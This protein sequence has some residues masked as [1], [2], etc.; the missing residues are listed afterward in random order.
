MS[1]VAG[2]RDHRS[3]GRPVRITSRAP[4]LPSPCVSH[5]VEWMS[6]V[7]DSADPGCAGSHRAG[8]EPPRDRVEL[9]RMGEPKCPQE[10]AHRRGRRD[11]V[12]QHRGGSRTRAERVDVVDAIAT[13]QQRVDH[14]QALLIRIRA[15]TAG[16][17]E[18]LLQQ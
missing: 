2:A 16:H 3:S 5:S 15:R 14:G 10:R 18:A 4:S 12:T 8:Q 9:S 1:D 17:R 6:T 11:P 13:G 7:T